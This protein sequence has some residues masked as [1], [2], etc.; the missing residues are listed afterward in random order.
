MKTKP[1]I[2]KQPACSDEFLQAIREAARTGSLIYTESF[3]DWAR[4]DFCGINHY[5]SHYL[6]SLPEDEGKDLR[7]QIEAGT[8]V[9]DIGDSGYTIRMDNQTWVEG[10]NCN[11]LRR[12]EDWLT[13]NVEWILKFYRYRAHSMMRTAQVAIKQLSEAGCYHAKQQPSAQPAFEQKGRTREMNIT[14]DE[15]EEFP[16]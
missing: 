11:G 13:F 5:L 10:C 6:S 2:K 16:F 7:E 15:R 3:S 8:A 1:Q 9:C 12:F 4:C 14:E